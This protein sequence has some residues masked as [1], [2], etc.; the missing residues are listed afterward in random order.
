MDGIEISGRDREGAPCAKVYERAFLIVLPQ[1]SDP[2]RN[3]LKAHF[4]APDFLAVAPFGI[5]VR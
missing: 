4:E 2:Y 1:V 3:M 5:T